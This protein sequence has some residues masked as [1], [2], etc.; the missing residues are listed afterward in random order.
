VSLPTYDSA[1]CPL[2]LAGQPVVKPG[3]RA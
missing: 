1:S 2:C 3:S